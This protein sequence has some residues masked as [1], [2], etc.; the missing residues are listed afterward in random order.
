[1]RSY[2]K[3]KSINA[4]WL[5]SIPEHWKW[6]RIKSVFAER[7]ERNNPVI[8]TNILSLTANQ[9]VVPYSE[10]ESPGGNKPKSD[11]TEYNV[12]RENDL[13]VNCMNIVSG[14]AGVSR[15][16]GAISPVYYALYSREN[17]NIWYFHYLFRL[18]SFQRSLIGLGKGILM[19]ESDNGK[20]NTVRMR[21]SMDY[22]GNVSIPVPPRPEQDQIVRY[23]D[24]QVSRIDRLIEGKKREIELLKELKKKI[25]NQAVTRGLKQGIQWKKT[26]VVWLTDVPKHWSVVRG[27]SI[28]VK[29]ERPVEA[30]DEVVTVFRDGQVCRR[31]KR[32]EE[33]FTF[34][35]LEIGYQGI[36]KGDLAVHGMDGFAGAIGI[37]EDRG[38]CSP[39]INVLTLRNPKISDVHYICYYLRMLAFNN[40]FLA[41]STGIRERSCDLRWKKIADLEFIL[42][43]LEEQ[44]EI[45]NYINEND[46]RIDTQIKKIVWEI[47]LLAEIKVRIVS[48]AVTGKM[49]VR[50]VKTER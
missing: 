44:V 9:G 36:E 10:R 32:R 14:S 3:V 26:D 31:S 6:K 5:E 43:P 29:M 49:D 16:T 15:Y 37:S 25:L 7:K 17:D 48:D 13:L 19:R 28:L 38:K 8:T 18:I 39:V 12:A 34:S 22:L 11:L 45:V 21:I 50:S 2:P 33:G 23:L 40:T 4:S 47:N 27:K 30:T 1:M 42:P 41:L 35:I 20:L 24:W 46:K